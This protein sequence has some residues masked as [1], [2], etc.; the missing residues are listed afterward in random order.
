[1][2]DVHKKYLSNG[3]CAQNTCPMDD[4]HKILVQWTM[5]T[6]YLS[7]GRCA[8]N[9]CPMD[10]VHKMLVQWTMCTNACQWTTVCAQKCLSI[11][12]RCVHKNTCPLDDGVCTKILVHWTAMCAQNTCPIGSI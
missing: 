3:R 5:C 12:R 9:T 8:Q 1:M 4:V 6:K 7:N 11:G 2:D 10:D